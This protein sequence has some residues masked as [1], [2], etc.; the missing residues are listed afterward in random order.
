MP[1]EN[2]SSHQDTAPAEFALR[3][4]RQTL[5]Q[6]DERMVNELDLS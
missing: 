5:V 2:S 6:R 1:G 4:Y 3:V